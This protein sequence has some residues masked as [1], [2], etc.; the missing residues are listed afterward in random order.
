MIRGKIARLPYGIK[1]LVL[2]EAINLTIATVARNLPY[3]RIGLANLA[4]IT[5]MVIGVVNIFASHKFMCNNNLLESDDTHPLDRRTW[6]IIAIL[7]LILWLFG[8]RAG[9][10]LAEVFSDQNTIH[11]QRIFGEASSVLVLLSV[12]FVGPVSEEFVFRGMFFTSVRHDLGA[13]QAAIITAV[14]FVLVH[15]T[16]MHVFFTFGLG[17]MLAYIMQKTNNIVDCIMLHIGFNFSSAILSLLVS[18]TVVDTKF[19]QVI[20]NPWICVSVS[21]AAFIYIYIK[22]IKDLPGKTKGLSN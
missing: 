8:G 1:A 22:F 5:T 9:D 4:M 6:I 19:F 12:I 3:E 2:F 21:L 17:L 15:H 18:A 11:Y 16:L 10:Y 20:K 14:F 7:S 13:R